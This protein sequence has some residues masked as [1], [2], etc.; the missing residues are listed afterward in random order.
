MPGVIGLNLI[1]NTYNYKSF[2]DILKVEKLIDSY[3]FF[4]EFDSWNST[5]G[6]LIIGALPHQIYEKKYDENDLLKTLSSE[7]KMYIMK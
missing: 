5:K 1:T 6:N 4:F 2:L 7:V 3:Y